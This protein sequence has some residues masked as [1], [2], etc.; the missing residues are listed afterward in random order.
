VGLSALTRALGGP[1]PDDRIASAGVALAGLVAAAAGPRLLVRGGPHESLG[2]TCLARPIAVMAR[3][4]AAAAVSVLVAAAAVVALGAPLLPAGPDGLAAAGHA[5]VIAGLAG[6][7]APRIG[8]SP[9]TVLTALLVA[10]GALGDGAPP[11]PVVLLPPPGFAVL[12]LTRS[13]G[14]P[15]AAAIVGWVVL[16]GVAAWAPQR[17]HR[18]TS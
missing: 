5:V 13:G 9:A 11:P 2:W 8:C 14:L 7:L 4:A 17:P 1:L 12:E 10:A 3:L 18:R 16:A 6:G 15:A